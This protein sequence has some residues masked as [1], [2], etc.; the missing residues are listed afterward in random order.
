MKAIPEGAKIICPNLQ[1]DVPIFE[2]TEQFE[3]GESLSLDKLRALHPNAV[4]S[5]ET[6]TCPQCGYVYMRNGAVHTH[7]GWFPYAP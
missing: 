2:F 4:R 1:C 7:F 6:C 5:S 3:I